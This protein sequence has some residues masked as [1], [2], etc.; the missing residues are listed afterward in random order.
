MTDDDETWQTN[1]KAKHS[2][3]TRTDTK[4]SS[5]RQQGSSNKKSNKVMTGSWVGPK[6]QND[7]RNTSSEVFVR[8]HE[9]NTGDNQRNTLEVG[10]ND[11][12]ESQ[13]LIEVCTDAD[14]SARLKIPLSHLV[15]ELGEKKE[16]AKHPAVETIEKK[17]SPNTTDKGQFNNGVLVPQGKAAI[18]VELVSFGYKYGL[19][20][21]GWSHSH[22]L[23]RVDC[24]DLP[25][26]PLNM[27]RLSGLN[28]H[29]K[30]V[31]SRT[32]E[33]SVFC[34]TGVCCPMLLSPAM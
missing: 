30:R 6:T 15:E 23:P 4:L 24:R 29:V 1:T 7:R 13:E 18:S 20:R 5:S 26:V 22:P 12:A 10:V 16:L 21:C 9:K 17:H 25:E 28:H 2:N 31:L 14:F 19:A 8:Q 32:H 3:R 33:V 11:E 34:C 27:A